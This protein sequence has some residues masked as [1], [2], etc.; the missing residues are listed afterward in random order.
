MRMVLLGAGRGSR[1]GHLT[2]DKPKALVEI[3]GRPIIARLLEVAN[4]AG[5]PTPLLVTG[6]RAEAFDAYDVETRH[7]P[8]WAST[9]MVSSLLCAQDILRSEETLVSY[10]DIL[11]SSEDLMQ[12]GQ[13]DA[14]ISVAYDP[15]WHDLWA[16]RFSDPLSDAETFAINAAGHITEIGGKPERIDTIAGQYTGLLKFKP[17]GWSRV[18]RILEELNEQSIGQMDMTSLLRRCIHDHG[19]SVTGVAMSSPWFEIDSAND[20]EVAQI[21]MGRSSNWT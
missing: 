8:A 9:N 11:Y 19:I 20:I 16:K 1:L 12:L 3:G 15:N 4:A 5:L 7:N 21:L 6:Y 2:Q 13:S 17:E 18:A 10:T 14:P